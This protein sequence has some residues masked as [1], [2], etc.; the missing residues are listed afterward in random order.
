MTDSLSTPCLLHA[1]PIHVLASLS[2]NE[3]LLSKWSVIFRNLLFNVFNVGLTPLYIYKPG[4][5]GCKKHRLHFCGG[6]RPPPHSEC[7]GYDTEQSD[8]EAPVILTFREIGS[9]PSVPSIP[10]PLWLGVVASDRALALGQIELI[11]GNHLTLLTNAKLNCLKSS[12][13]I[14]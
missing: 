13:L 9:T 14:I 3:I 2:V 8:G 12:C 7:P 11:H 4:R 10:R 6:I 5:L 1:F